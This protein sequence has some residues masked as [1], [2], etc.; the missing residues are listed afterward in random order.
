MPLNM[1]TTPIDY[2]K[3]VVEDAKFEDN[4]VVTLTGPN[5]RLKAGTILARSVA[6]PTKYNLFVVGGA[7]DGN[8]VPA[9]I[10]TYDTVERIAGGSGD[11]ACRPAIGGEFNFNRLVVDAAG[12]NST[13]TKAHLDLLRARGFTCSNVTQLGG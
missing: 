8:G 4:V 2:G 6:D 10:L 7:S 5:K 12:N 11:V 3:P 1:T 9:A 13:L